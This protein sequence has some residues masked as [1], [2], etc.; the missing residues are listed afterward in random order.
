ML[1]EAAEAKAVGLLTLHF[2][3]GAVDARVENGAKPAYAKPKTGEEPA[4][5]QQDLF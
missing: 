4:A 3:D 2:A 1:T 5:R